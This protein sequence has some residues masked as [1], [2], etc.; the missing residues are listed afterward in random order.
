VTVIPSRARDLA[1]RSGLSP[2]TP[3]LR[4]QQQQLRKPERDLGGLPHGTHATIPLCHPDPEH[5]TTRHPE[6]SEG[7]N[8]PAAS[9]S[10]HTS[11]LEPVTAAAN[12]RK[13]RKPERDL[14]SLRRGTHATIPLCHPDPEH[15]T[16]RHPEQS[17][18]STP[19]AWSL[20]SSN[21]SCES[22]LIAPN[23]TPVSFGLRAFAAIVAVALAA[24]RRRR[25]TGPG[26][27]SG[28]R[29]P[30]PSPSLRSGSGSD[31][32]LLHRLGR[33]HQIG[34]TEVTNQLHP[35]TSEG[36]IASPRRCSARLRQIFQVS[37][38]G[39]QRNPELGQCVAMRVAMRCG[40][41]WW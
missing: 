38:C 35:R 7:S 13:K 12:P 24:R 5:P 4:Q 32:S 25:V 1:R 20:H 6:Q 33:I 15:P 28:R 34:R 30:S 21:S 27:V 29:D 16:T 19:P 22:S 41:A 14:S 2:R 23:K 10:S 39:C 9:L 8:P 40:A 11:S 26:S 37:R 17:E 3:P 31:D 36:D 18:G